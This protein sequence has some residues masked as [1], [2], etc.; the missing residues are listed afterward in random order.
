LESLEDRMLLYSPLG[1]E[2]SLPIR[3]TYSFVPDGTSIGGISS[4]LHGAMA[5]R[6][7]ST[8]SW[9]DQFR[10]AAA[11]WASVA[12][13]NLVESYD[14]GTSFAA[15]GYQQG[16]SRFGDLRIG[17]MGLGGNVLATAYVSPPFN[18]GTLAGDI[19]FNT[20]QFWN[21]GSS[22][23]IQTVAIHEFGHALGLG[24]S[25]IVQAAMYAAYTGVKPTLNGDDVAGM[26]SVYGPRTQDGFDQSS[27]NQSWTTAT[28]LDGFVGLNGQASLPGLELT[29]A[30]D[31]DWYTVVAPDGGSGHLVVRMQSSGHSLLSPRVTVFNS[32]LQ[33]IALATSSSYGSTVAVTIPNV[34]E[35]QRYFIRAT[36]GA[37]GPSGVGRY[38]LQ[39]NFGLQTQLAVSPPITQIFEQPNQGGGALNI[40]VDGEVPPPMPPLAPPPAPPPGSQPP[41][42]PTTGDGL[43]WVEIGVIGGWGE[44]LLVS[45]DGVGGFRGPFPKE[46]AGLFWID[47]AIEELESLRTAPQERRG[48]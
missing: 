20:N 17:G 44:T 18:G 38:A 13:F 4:N 8:Q 15:G 35:G 10:R 43:E 1:G 30:A 45:S 34:T 6:G 16:D 42:L 47:Q 32:N 2:W 7:F 46:A 29:T 41:P 5:A 33:Q 24:H 39:L 21:L 27:S 26:R 36:A 14:N 3:V 23:D 25:T 22:Y 40:L 12:G 37:A 19:V 28:A 9:Q 31:Q 11:V 48:R